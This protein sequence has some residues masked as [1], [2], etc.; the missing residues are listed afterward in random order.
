VGLVMPLLRAL[1]PDLAAASVGGMVC[2]GVLV[3]A[4]LIAASGVGLVVARGGAAVLLGAWLSHRRE[5]GL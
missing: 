4:R 3:P 2:D 1:L 5:F